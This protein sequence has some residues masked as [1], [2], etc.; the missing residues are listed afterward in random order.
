[1]A[2]FNPNAPPPKPAPER[3]ETKQDAPPASDAPTEE[4]KEE[5]TPATDGDGAGDGEGDDKGDPP[6]GDDAGDEK[7]D[8]SKSKDEGKPKEEG[9]DEP[10]VRRKYKSAKDYIIERKQR[11]L[12]K[13]K[14]K[15]DEGG[16]D[17]G[18]D[19]DDDEISPEDEALVEKV[20]EKKYGP[21]L[22]KISEQEDTSELKDFLA[23]N[24]DFKP[25]EAKIR[26]Y[27]AHPSRSQVPVSAIAYEVAG[28]E[29][30]KL[31][32]KRKAAADD[33]AKKGQAGGGSS[34]EDER[35]GK[36]SVKDMTPKEFAE[37]KE[38]VRLRNRQ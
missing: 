19:G 14:S 37:Y 2:D 22:K 8:K 13:A 9:D 3:E 1:M 21:A 32:A 12:D 34:R 29:L 20:V 18:D 17:E 35:G 30:L 27:M 10:P 23:E 5:E 26:R 15:K 31:G 11:Q 28:P 4:A 6:E 33:K 24:P 25:Y 7:P 16:D 38:Q 36:K